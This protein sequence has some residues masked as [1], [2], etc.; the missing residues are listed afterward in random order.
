[1]SALSLFG[2]R[3]TPLDSEIEPGRD[4]TLAPDYRVESRESRA[5]GFSAPLTPEFQ[6]PPDSTALVEALI[7]GS[8]HGFRF[9]FPGPVD[10]SPVAIDPEPAAAHAAGRDPSLIFNFDGVIGQADLTLTGTGTDTTTGA[11]DRYGFHTDM[12]FMAGKFIGTDGRVHRGT[13]AFI[14]LGSVLVPN[15]TASGASPLGPHLYSPG[16]SGSDVVW[17][18]EIPEASV[19]FDLREE[20]A[21][22]H[23]K[24]VFVFDAF[25]VPNALNTFHPM[26]KVHAVI[27][28]L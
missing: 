18:T 24:N 9:F 5:A 14:G 22:L 15:P 4:G 12:R 13:F 8:T 16:V 27:N 26:G 1:L 21:S 11:S 25:T 6:V 3:P 28:S 17:T 20:E 23:L 19:E 2:S 10:G 7:T